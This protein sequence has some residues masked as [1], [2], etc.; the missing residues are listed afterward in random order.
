MYKWIGSLFPNI[1]DPNSTSGSSR[2]LGYISTLSSPCHTSRG[3][4]FQDSGILVW[5][6]ILTDETKR[7]E[8]ADCPK[9]VKIQ[10]GKWK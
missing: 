10:Q 2:P 3:Q 1:F 8:P 4:D 5:T 6:M 7:R 9:A